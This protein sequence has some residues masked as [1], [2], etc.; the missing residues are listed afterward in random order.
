MDLPTVNTRAGLYVFFNSMVSLRPIGV[1][2]INVSKLTAR[3]LTDDFIIIN[4]L[5]SRYKVGHRSSADDE[6]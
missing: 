5:H 4:Y 2:D 1:S 6:R 3:P